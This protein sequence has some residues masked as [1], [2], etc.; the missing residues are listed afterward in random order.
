[1]ATIAFKSNKGGQW[2]YLI[3][4]YLG[5][6][7]DE[8]GKKKKMQPAKT[9]ILPPPE[10]GETLNNYWT[11]AK[12]DSKAQKLADEWE[13]ELKNAG[14][15]KG[16]DT[17]TF[18]AYA[19]RFL[20]DPTNS[21]SD[22]TKEGYEYALVRIENEKIQIPQ[23]ENIS[24]LSYR[25]GDIALKE[26]TGRHLKEFY[27]HLRAH[28]YN[29]TDNYATSNILDKLRLQRRL[30]K[31]KLAVQAGVSQ[32]TLLNACRGQHV[33][34]P[35]AER[36]AAALGEDVTQVF[37]IHFTEKPLS[38][39]TQNAYHRF[40]STVLTSAV[41]DEI[42]AGNVAKGLSKK[43]K[44]IAHNKETPHF[45]LQQ[46]QHFV[47]VVTAWPDIRVKTVLL[48]TLAL[49]GRR[50]EVCA[51]SVDGIDLDAG[52]IYI[53][54][55]LQ[56]I[57]GKGLVLD[58]TKTE[59]SKR[60]LSPGTFTM[61]VMREYMQWLGRV[62]EGREELRDKQ[63]KY[64]FCQVDGSPISPDTLNFWLDKVITWSNNNTD[65]VLPRITPHGLRH[66][67]ET[68]MNGEIGLDAINTKA[69]AGQA[70]KS[71][72]HLNYMHQLKNKQKEAAQ[73]FDELLF[74]NTALA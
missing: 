26:L 10:P 59:E 21:L 19:R 44:P 29:E 17:L 70:R 46:A 54:K 60:S 41:D 11:Q 3:R 7:I 64:L 47:S 45:N 40:V 37:Q 18:S 12:A 72:I 34:I 58:D 61:G 36:I 28:C 50:G 30:S 8:N 23:Y 24:A 73:K 43:S 74:E 63:W 62:F 1:M 33:R 48:T 4:A 52:T 53:E 71:T 39:T 14:K 55:S 35:T 15:G 2:K 25:L 13:T 32:S 69:M 56:Y 65:V 9:I 38:D 68:L 6:T 42:L 67:F 27:G 22:K 16:D 31:S 57:K 51:L 66:T 20:A 49:A 5:D